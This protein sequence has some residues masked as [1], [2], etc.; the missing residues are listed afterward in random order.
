MKISLWVKLILNIFWRLFKLF[1]IAE[2]LVNFISETRTSICNNQKTKSSMRVSSNLN[3]ATQVIIRVSV[4]LLR[5]LHSK[6]ISPILLQD[7]GSFFDGESDFIR[8]VRFT[9]DQPSLSKMKESRWLWGNMNMTR[10]YCP[11]IKITK[12]K[13]SNDTE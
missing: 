1:L 9:E 10:I 3:L 5:L 2:I 8:Q 11:K 13:Q 12:I 7:Y 4:L 6:N